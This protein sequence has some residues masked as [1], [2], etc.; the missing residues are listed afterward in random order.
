MSRQAKSHLKQNFVY[1]ELF[2]QMT[3]GILSIGEHIATEEASALELIHAAQSRRLRVPEDLK[4]AFE[5]PNTQTNGGFPI[6]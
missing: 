5:M 2:Q 3:T 6:L 4:T 1:Q